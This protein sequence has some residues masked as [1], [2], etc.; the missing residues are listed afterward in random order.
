M[1]GY[2]PS[3]DFYEIHY[4]SCRHDC[5]RWLD[6]LR[7]HSCY[8]A[9]CRRTRSSGRDWRYGIYR[10]DWFDWVYR[11]NWLHRINRLHGIYRIHG[12]D[13][14]NGRNRRYGT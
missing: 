5:N 12:L 6:S 10:F 7:P 2:K 1:Q 14:F 11:L 3:K 13:R 8:P 9:G 4:S